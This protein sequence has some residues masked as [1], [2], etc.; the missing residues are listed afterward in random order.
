MYPCGG[1]WFFASMA[2]YR[3]HL[4]FGCGPPQRQHPTNFLSGRSR[5]PRAGDDPRDPEPDRVRAVLSWRLGGRPRDWSFCSA[6]IDSLSAST[7][8]LTFVPSWLMQLTC[9]SFVIA[10]IVSCISKYVARFDFQHGFFVCAMPML[11]V[12]VSLGRFW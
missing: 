1:P 2:L 5:P 12:Q 6:A 3:S 11:R 9:Y 8:F 4:A 10:W 7:C